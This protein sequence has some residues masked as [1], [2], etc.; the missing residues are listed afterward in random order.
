M[1]TAGFFL[2]AALLLSA[3][4]SPSPS[5]DARLNS[6]I[7][8]DIARTE[9]IS[10]ASGVNVE[11]SRG[12]VVLTGFLET[13]QQ[14]QDAAQAALKVAGVQQVFNNIQVLKPTSSGQ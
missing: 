4:A 14:R 9:G 10:N 2:S 6:R 1:K 11:S 7:K 5:P 12:V 13:E 3:C 8:Q